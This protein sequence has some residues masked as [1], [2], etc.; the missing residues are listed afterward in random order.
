M[1]QATRVARRAVGRRRRKTIHKNGR[2][3]AHTSFQFCTFRTIICTWWGTRAMADSNSGQVTEYVERA[4]EA[5]KYAQQAADE[6]TKAEWLKV[7]EKW[8]LLAEQASKRA[9]TN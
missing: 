9:S 5:R 7:A 6:S 4:R 1:A 2:R 8:A 3:A